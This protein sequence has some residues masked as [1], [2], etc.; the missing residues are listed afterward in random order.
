[1]EKKT[2]ELTNEFIKEHFDI[3]SCLKKGLINYS[4][5]ARHI[6]EDLKIEKKSSKEA[7][8]V[9][10]IRLKK[11]L[12]SE[13]SNEKRVQSL[14][15]KSE[16]EIKNKMAV[17]VLPKTASPESLESVQRKIRKESGRYYAIQG[18][19][20]HT[21]I[22]EQANLEFIKEKFGHEIEKT[23]ENLVLINI[24]SPEEIETTTG[25]IAHISELF[26]ENNINVVELMS[27]WT[28]T[29]I[30]IDAKD[31]N[32]AIGFLKL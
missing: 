5:L 18:S 24:K 13:R 3:K 10:A 22:T 30:I 29:I 26:A 23:Q 27:C 25:V 6:S 19:A 4:A 20:N 28:D 32:K 31:L 17:A 1:M 21:I 7:I 15:S 11:R 2:S 8:L 12:E 9:S 14:L 16:M